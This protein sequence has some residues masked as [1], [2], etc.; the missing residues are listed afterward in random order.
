MMMSGCRTVAD[1]RRP[2]VSEPVWHRTGQIH[3]VDSRSDRGVKASIPDKQKR[4]NR[5]LGGL[6][7]CASAQRRSVLF[8]EPTAGAGLPL[9]HVSAGTRDPD[10]GLTSSPPNDTT[11]T[12]GLA[13]PYRGE[14]RP[15]AG[16]PCQSSSSPFVPVFGRLW[17]NRLGCARLVLNGTDGG[18]GALQTRPQ[19]G[20]I[21]S[22][23]HRRRRLPPPSPPPPPRTSTHQRRVYT[24]RDRMA[25]GSAGR[26]GPTSAL[27]WL[28]NVCIVSVLR[29]MC[30]SQRASCMHRARMESLPS[31]VH[32]A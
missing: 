11:T 16:R 14:G 17:P 6:G 20:N 18:G 22:A 23:L 2:R 13:P 3:T 19:R 28:H 8:E 26:L 7:R 27:R 24:V 25:N 21:A 31:A 9:R 32:A 15:D 10:A 30:G 4:G 12:H 5:T 1:R 29:D